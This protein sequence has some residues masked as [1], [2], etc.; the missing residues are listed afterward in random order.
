[1]DDPFG[2]MMGGMG[3]GSG[4]CNCGRMAGRSAS[5]PASMAEPAGGGDR[6]FFAQRREMEKQA[7]ID[8]KV[9]ALREAKEAEE[10]NRE[11]ERDLEKIVKARVQAWQREKKNLRALLASLHEIAPPCSWQPMTLAQLLDPSAVK[12]G[13]RK[14]LLA[15][16]P[17]KQ[18]DTDIEAKVLAQH[19][20]DALR[21]A[22]NLF[23]KTG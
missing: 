9:E 3:G 19:V 4:S 5:M 20:F 1:M 22:W 17:D 6:A 18:K 23:E 14:A 8:A 12:K 11:K 10:S 2:D 13:Y 15:V 16:H 7:A 21:D